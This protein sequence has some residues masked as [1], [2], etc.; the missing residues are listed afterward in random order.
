MTVRLYGHQLGY[1]SF[2]QVTRGFALALGAKGL[3]GGFVPL[4][5]FDEEAEYPGALCPVSVNTG[6]PSGVARAKVLGLHDERWLM[7]APNS[8]RIPDRMAQWLPEVA[9][10]L[11]APSRWGCD[12]LRSI[13]DLP[14]RLVPHGVHSEYRMNHEARAKRRAEWDADGTFRVLHMTSTNSERKG[15][16]KLL[17][18]WATLR[19]GQWK[20]KKVLTIV[21]RHEG[22]PELVS[23][24]ARLG[25]DP[26]IIASDGAHYDAVNELYAR[27]HVVCQPSRA[28]GFG[29]VPLEAKAA[30]VPVVMTDCTG[31]RDH[32]DVGASVI[33]ETGPL[34]P[35]DDMEG[36]MTPSLEVDAIYEALRDAWT[37][38]GDLDD[39]ARGEADDIRENYSWPNTTGRAME[40]INEGK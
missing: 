9:T 13:F 4:D 26:V 6:M 37:S 20:A 1:T 31:H 29:L 3:F 28:E 17:Q 19:H 8:D 38:Y 12:V 22:Y 11:L 24:A 16:K 14:V 36:A 27:S 32:A 23:E 2:S 21:V 35:S 34:A 30:G 10:G 40:D 33:V 7:L 39:V 25:I 15:T 18:A 5:F